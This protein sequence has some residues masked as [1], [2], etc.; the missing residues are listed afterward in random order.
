MP[1]ISLP[2]GISLSYRSHPDERPSPSRPTLVLL[3][4]FLQRAEIQFTPQ[5]RDPRFAGFNLVA[6]DVH[7]QGDTT[8]RES[9]GY[10]DNAKD[11]V[12]ALVS[13][14]ELRMV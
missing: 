5:L 6:V 9:W 14:W 10:A 2:N 8:G 13:V 7:G 4:S 11:V 12:E 3:P 1:S